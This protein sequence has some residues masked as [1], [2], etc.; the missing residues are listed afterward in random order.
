MKDRLIRAALLGA[1]CI[2]PD[3]ALKIGDFSGLKMSDAGDVDADTL[4]ATVKTLRESKA[5]LFAA[6]STSST[7]KDPAVEPATAK[8]VLEMTD[9]EYKAARFRLVSDGVLA[10]TRPVH[11]FGSKSA[12]D[13][14][15]EEYQ[16]A[17]RK[18]HL[19]SQLAVGRSGDWSLLPRP[20]AGPQ[21]RNWAASHLAA[22]QVRRYP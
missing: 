8:S 19:P 10:R 18:A 14:T 6:P 3:V 5:Y 22:R 20:E 16:A 2:D 17:R 1:G 7:A 9:K 15:P 12:L 21:P 4:Q 11:D 13:M